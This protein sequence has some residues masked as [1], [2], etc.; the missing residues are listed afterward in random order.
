M[1]EMVIE[2]EGLKKE[3]VSELLNLGVCDKCTLRYLGVKDPVVYRNTASIKTVSQLF[4]YLFLL[5]KP[6]LP[7]RIFIHIRY[8]EVFPKRRM[9]MMLQTLTLTTKK[10]LACLQQN[11]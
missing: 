5:I 8:L 11:C 2:T 1:I 4:S 7:M 9:T 6:T 3:I 10:G